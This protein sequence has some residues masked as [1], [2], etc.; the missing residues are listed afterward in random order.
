MDLLKRRM[1]MCTDKSWLIGGIK[2]V[3]KA[4]FSLKYKAGPETRVEL[5]LEFGTAK[6]ETGLGGSIIYTTKD[7]NKQV[8]GINFGA[9]AYQ[10]LEGIYYWNDVSI[11]DGGSVKITGVDFRNKRLLLS[12]GY[13]NGDNIGSVKCGR[14]VFGT[15]SLNPKKGTCKNDIILLPGF[16]QSDL[17]V[18]YGVKIFESDVLV[19]DIRPYIL[20][21]DVFMMCR[22]TGEV[23]MP[24][25]GVFEV[26][27]H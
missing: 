7:D 6:T 16:S 19:R 1:M 15:V 5:D 10:Y 18:V 4:Y 11:E 23:Y 20:G 27:T 12:M 3:G 13:N 2:K 26:F 22:K 8:F 25:N 9:S 24:V 21:S 17:A 14:D